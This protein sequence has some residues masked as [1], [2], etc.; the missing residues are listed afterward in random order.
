MKYQQLEVADTTA[1]GFHVMPGAAQSNMAS[2]TDLLW[3]TERFD[4]GSDFGANSGR[5]FA[6]PYTGKYLFG[7][8]IRIDDPPVDGAWM[9][10]QQ[11]STNETFTPTIY[12][13]LNLYGGTRPVYF[14]WNF[15]VMCA[16]DAADIF[17][18]S[19]HQSGGSSTADFHTESVLWGIGL[20]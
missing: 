18:C 5:D 7:G 9:R 12:G 14:H 19:W 2:D 13:Q 4:N 3:T 10:P 8:T 17:Y 6:A 15:S 20:M 11:K 1:T 16:M